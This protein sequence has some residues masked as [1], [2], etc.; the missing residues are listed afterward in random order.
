L[1]VAHANFFKG[2]ISGTF[3]R[4]YQLESDSFSRPFVPSN[5]KYKLSAAVGYGLANTML[6]SAGGSFIVVDAGS[7][8]NDV[9]DRIKAFREAGVLPSQGKLHISAIIYTH[10]HIDHTGGADY[11]LQAS[12]LP[13][14]PV[15]DANAGGVDGIYHA[16]SNCVEI[17]AQVGVTGNIVDTATR[18]GNIIDARSAYMYGSAFSTNNTNGTSGNLNCGIGPK[19]TS[20]PGGSSF[21]SSSKSMSTWLDVRTANGLQL[22][23]RYAPSETSDEIIVFLPDSTNSKHSGGHSHAF[24]LSGC[25]NKEGYTFP[26][27]P[28]VSIAALGTGALLSAEVIQGPSF[29]NLYSLRGTTFRNPLTWYESVDILRQFNSWAMVPSHGVPLMGQS[30]IQTLL[31]NFRDAVQVVHDQ[32][33][34]FF[35]QGFLPDEVVEMVHLP[36]YIVNNLASLI[37]GLPPSEGMDPLDYLRTFYGSVPQGVREIYVGYLG[38]NEGDAT[39]F[40]PL[41]PTDRARRYVAA[42]GGSENVLVKA[43]QS[44]ML[45][46]ETS[47]KREFQWCAELLIYVI[48]AG[49]ERSLINKARVLKASA[50]L[51][52]AQT[53]SSTI[54]VLENDWWSLNPNWRNWLVTGALEL[55]LAT[56]GISLPNQPED[57]LIGPKIQA[58]VPPL[59]YVQQWCWRFRPENA[60]AIDGQSFG[61]RFDADTIYWSSSQQFFVLVVA[62]SVVRFISA[63]SSSLESAWA[64][65]TYQMSVPSW[66]AFSALTQVDTPTPANAFSI[67][68]KNLL[69]SNTLVPLRGSPSSISSFFSNVYFDQINAESPSIV[70]RHGPISD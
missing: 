33:L 55:I 14:C 41:P 49:G 23:L 56:K 52:L 53:T 60:S 69:D 39:L 43:N 45:G 50:L 59:N 9:R 3:G 42:M 65:A 10:N 1:T 44:Y 64:S 37:S 11:W 16:R 30:N 48:R 40:Q 63:P 67:G 27:P 58:S 32:S 61:F 4:V 51:Q 12:L 25:S 21:Q 7:G 62:K 18:T 68:L 54:A 24:R 38:W 2:N 22:W 13:R 46:K 66:L 34:R 47:D 15:E 36:Q 19:E 6:I 20:G 57:G 26:S 29:P 31:V 28:P 70:G 5:L 17:I 35:R 8:S